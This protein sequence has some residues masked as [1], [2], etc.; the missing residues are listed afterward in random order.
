MKG[1]RRLQHI[2]K[3]LSSISNSELK[4]GRSTTFREVP[5]KRIVVV[6]SGETG[7]K[8]AFSLLMCQRAKAQ[9]ERVASLPMRVGNE[10]NCRIMVFIAMVTSLPMRVGNASLERSTNR[11]F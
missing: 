1:Y 6:V 8:E 3:V 5:L 10:S 9:L 11:G 2:E 4:P 7:K